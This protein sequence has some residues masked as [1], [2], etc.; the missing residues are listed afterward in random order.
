MAGRKKAKGLTRRQA[1][2]LA[3]IERHLIGRSVPPT[4]RDLCAAVG[5]GTSFVHESLLEMERKKFVRWWK[6]NTGRAGKRRR[7]VRAVQ[8]LR[9]RDGDRVLWGGEWYEFI[10]AARLGA[11]RGEEEEGGVRAGGESR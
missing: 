9:R 2:I 3:A 8:I 10:P 1:D 4:V 5:S 7:E 6:R 11:G